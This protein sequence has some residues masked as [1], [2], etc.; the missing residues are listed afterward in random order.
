[1]LSLFIAAIVTGQTVTKLIGNL[2]NTPY[3]LVTDGTYMYLGNTT[4][5]NFQR[6]NLTNLSETPTT[7]NFINSQ[8]MMGI[9]NGYLYLASFTGNNIQR[10]P[11]NNLNSVSEIVISLNRAVS[12][13][14]NGDYL[15]AIDNDNGIFRYDMSNANPEST[16]TKLIDGV[17]IEDLIVIKDT[18]YYLTASSLYKKDLTSTNTSTT[19]GVLV[20]NGLSGAQEIEHRGNYFYISQFNNGGEVVRYNI[21]DNIHETFIT[22]ANWGTGVHAIGM[23]ILD[24]K[25]YI[26]T[27]QNAAPWENA[28]YTT[29]LNDDPYTYIPDTNFEQALIEA[30]HCKG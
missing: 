9:R 10:I 22:A 11:L 7:Y 23:F 19:D 17:F 12:F 29:V 28:I 16:K 30:G 6:Y 2:T 21:Q 24:N 20:F 1:M 27:A 26:S 13:H 8:N 4:A 18:L 15:Y 3:G 5:N 14:F 25:L